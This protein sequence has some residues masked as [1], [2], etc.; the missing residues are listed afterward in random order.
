MCT[1]VPDK[2]VNHVFLPP[3]IWSAYING[4]DIILYL[5]RKDRKVIAYSCSGM[6]P[7]CPANPFQPCSMI[8]KLVCMYCKYRNDTVSKKISEIYPGYK[9]IR[10]GFGIND[11]EVVGNIF[12]HG[13]NG[14]YGFTVD[15]M[16]SSAI[17]NV[18][19]NLADSKPLINKSTIKRLGGFV[20]TSITSYIDAISILS[21]NELLSTAYVYNGRFS[22]YRPFV[23]LFLE[24]GNDVV[25]YEHPDSGDKTI[26]VIGDY[27]HNTLLFSRQLFEYKESNKIE[28]E[29][30]LKYSRKWIENRIS[31]RDDSS[32]SMFSK[33]MTASM[34]YED[35]SINSRIISFFVSSE[36]EIAS[37][38]EAINPNWPNQQYV[39]ESMLNLL[40]D[41]HMTW[42]VV[43]RMHPNLKGADKEFQDQVKSICGRYSKLCVYIPPESKSDS[44]ELI[45]ISDVVAVMN[46]TVGIEAALLG[47]KTITFGISQY[48]YFN[49]GFHPKNERDLFQLINDGSVWSEVMVKQK[50]NASY[51]LYVLHNFGLN[52]NNIRRSGRRLYLKI[53]DYVLYDRCCLGIRLVTAVKKR[54]DGVIAG[55]LINKI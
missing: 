21:D 30:A 41:S 33:S 35:I 28:E 43:V 46:S 27:V 25:T 51:F 44:Y 49:I 18:Q 24:A 54:I 22:R 16:L 8:G 53:G 48:Y 2:L 15:E 9:N 20:N 17:S 52:S 7:I 29:E 3:H 26:M 13:L 38:P 34:L 32:N 36:N 11:G 47:K 50:A 23:R 40:N 19:T 39:L 31:R 37:I 55:Q 45:R 1:N 42:Q 14:G 12:H 6:L 4:V 5:L 10:I